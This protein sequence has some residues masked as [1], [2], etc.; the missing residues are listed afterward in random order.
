[1]L[2]LCFSF[3][4]FFSKEII[5][6]I[7]TPYADL[8]RQSITTHQRVRGARGRGKRVRETERDP[9][10]NSARKPRK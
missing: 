7:L 2:I 1:L 9:E 4:R 6:E 5:L 10:N 8:A 3:A